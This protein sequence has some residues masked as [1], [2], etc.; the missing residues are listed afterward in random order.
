MYFAVTVHE[1]DVDHNIW[2]KRVPVL[3]GETT[4][5]KP[6]PVTGD[7]LHVLEELVTLHKYIYLIVD[8][9]FVNSNSFF[10]DLSRKI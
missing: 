7:L 8:L 1:I 10:L 3:K 5:K 6:I 9:F 4:R 2:G